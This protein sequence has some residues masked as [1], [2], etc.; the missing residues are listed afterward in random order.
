MIDINMG[1]PVPKITG[2]GEGSALMKTPE[3][4]GKVVEAI[5]KKIPK[6][7]TVKM[8]KGFDSDT[9]VEF[10]KRLE[11]SG[12][13]AVAVH[14][15]TREE[16]YTGK[17]DWDCIRRVK[18][19][20]SIPVIGSGDVFTPQDAKAMLSETGCDGIMLA[21][22]VRGNPWL[23]SQIHTY[24]KEGVVPDKPDVD[25]LVAMIK[26]HARLQI[27]WKG[28]Y[29]GIRQMRKHVGWYT[30][31]YPKAAALR[32]AVNEVESL[33]EL[34]SLLDSYKNEVIH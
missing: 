16:Y 15:R 29:L 22:G 21:R 3:L 4:A 8:R 2:N 28:E 33:E 34:D 20:V 19:A 31:G 11:A 27:Q 26:R 32:R 6:P 1:C 14:G 23:F 12:A 7:V 24:L 30:Q 25:T 17:A 13:A 9:S 18:E 10:A 5:A